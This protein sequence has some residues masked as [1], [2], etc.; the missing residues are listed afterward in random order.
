MLAYAM[1]RQCKYCVEQ[2]G[3]LVVLQQGNTYARIKFDVDTRHWV[4]IC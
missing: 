3:G 4:R 2:L 1:D